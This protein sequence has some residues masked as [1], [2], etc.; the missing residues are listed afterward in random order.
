MEDNRCQVYSIEPNG[1]IGNDLVGQLHQRPPHHVLHTVGGHDGGQQSEAQQLHHESRGEEE[2][3]A[4]HKPDGPQANHG[5]AGHCHL[6][7]T[8]VQVVGGLPLDDGGQVDPVHAAQNGCRVPPVHGPVVRVN[9]VDVEQR[10]HHQEACRGSQ[11]GVVYE[12][13]NQTDEWYPKGQDKERN[14]HSSNDVL[15]G[16]QVY[17]ITMISMAMN[18]VRS[19]IKTA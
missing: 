11:G 18:V 16:E 6:E 14:S 3:D 12:V 7:G 4:H 15:L 9:R 19:T 2:E 10:G 8:L 5:Q 13:I 1:S 17:K